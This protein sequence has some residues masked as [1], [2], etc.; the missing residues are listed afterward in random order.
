MG[1]KYPMRKLMRVSCLCAILVYLNACTTPKTDDFN[2]A[3]LNLTVTTISPLEVSLSWTTAEGAQ[4]YT[5]E[6][7]SEDE[8]EF[9]VVATVDAATQQ[10]SYTDATVESGILYTYY[11]TANA[12]GAVME[13]AEISI[14][15]PSDE[16]LPEPPEP[17]P[18]APKFQGL[19]FLLVKYLLSP[20]CLGLTSMTQA[21]N[22]R[23][24][25]IVAEA[26]SASLDGST[27]V[28]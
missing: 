10:T 17:H 16:N 22:P 27:N 14:E 19:K 4:S 1:V 9:A 2:S 23:R 21:V 15:V 11:L 12:N 25:R 13:S 24:I 3:T 18:Q 8:V 7:K 6:R 26:H 28:G 20:S 5:L